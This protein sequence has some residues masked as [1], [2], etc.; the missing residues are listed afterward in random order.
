M[1]I[2]DYMDLLDRERGAKSGQDEIWLVGKD[3]TEYFFLLC[4]HIVRQR[5]SSMFNPD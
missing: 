5:S 1:R 3:D 2:G 4:S